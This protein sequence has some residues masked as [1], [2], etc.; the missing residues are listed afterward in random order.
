MCEKLTCDTAVV[1]VRSHPQFLR[2]RRK[3]DVWPQ[4]PSHLPVLL[5]QCGVRGPHWGGG[6]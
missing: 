3:L 2:E 4:R 1:V 6:G 5:L